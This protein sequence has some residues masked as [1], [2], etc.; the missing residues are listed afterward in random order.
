M[1]TI[2]TRAGKGSPLTNTEVDDNFS[3][4]NSA[5]YESGSNVSFGGGSFSSNISVG[6]TVANNAINVSR[7]PNSSGAA[8]SSISLQAYSTNPA[9]NWTGGTLRFLGS[10]NAIVFNEDSNNMDFRIE[11]NDQANMLVVDA[12]TNTVMINGSGSTSSLYANGNTKLIVADGLAYFGNNVSDY[13][14]VPLGETPAIFA[15]RG[16]DH[17]TAGTTATSVLQLARD[18]TSG[19]SYAGMVDFSMSQWES[20][21][22]YSRTALHIRVGHDNLTPYDYDAVP[23]LVTIRSDGTIFN[24]QGKDK[25]FRVES[26]DLSHMLFVDA[27]NNRIGIGQSVPD[28]RLHVI[29]NSNQALMPLVIGNEDHT[30]NSTN[31]QVRMGFGLSRDS[32]TV[33]NNAGMIAVGKNLAWT[34]A[35]VNIDSFMGFSIFKN[36]ASTE[37][38]RIEPDKVRLGNT[39]DYVM[40]DVSASNA[41]IQLVDNTQTNPPTLRGNGSGFTIENGGV[42]KLRV[43]A[44]N[45]GVII[46]D[47]SGAM[48][49]RVE[50]DS[51]SH[52]LFVDGGENVVTM[53]MANPTIP[54][55]VGNNSVMMAD[56]LYMFQAADSGESNFNISQDNNY[57]Y[58]VHN[59]YWNGAWKQHNNGFGVQMLQLGSSQFHF[60]AA[61]DV[62]ADDTTAVLTNIFRGGLTEVC[63]NDSG[64]AVDFRVESDTKSHMLFVDASAHK[65]GINQSN[66]AAMLDIVTV[67]TAGSDAIRLRQPSSSETYQIQMGVSGATNEGLVLRSTASTGMLQQ[68]RANE[69]VINDDGVDRDFRIESNDQANMLFVDGGGNYVHF[70]GTAI[71]DNVVSIEAGRMFL[72]KQNDWNIESDGTGEHIRF[73]VSGTQKG[74]IT[75]NSSGT[76][77]STASDLRLKKDIETITDGTDKLMAMNPV[78]HGWKADPEADAVHG[79]IA[80][81]MMDIVPE[82]VSGDPEGEEMMSM[83]YGRIT[84]VLVAALQ[85]AHKK[86]AELETRLTELEGN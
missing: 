84:P 22:V 4:L 60:T 49:F 81:E 38:M 42:E 53:G 69:V 6:G 36:N 73:K 8:A 14:S 1:A 52:M 7:A 15:S 34:S 33:K 13:G 50:S 32:G 70:C 19:V 79:F 17:R 39:S 24:E 41:A 64:G 28:E 58:L 62:G 3:N 21:G 29:D 25:D 77:Y 48:D 56:N 2:T 37:T 65:I 57:V 5:K 12:A 74:S 9:F 63:V 78:T 23:E 54:S 43:K 61:A 27:Y 86:I 30:D 35:D 31:Q 76:T 59:G 18:G 55:F 45:D 71:G 47:P 46:N 83:D 75:S 85:D 26:N 40:V 72:N 80:Q 10:G 44:D 82:S 16:D 66:P 51:N 68:W 67:S 11:S 20:Q